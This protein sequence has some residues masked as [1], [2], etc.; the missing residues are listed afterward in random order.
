MGG[1]HAQF[2]QSKEAQTN[3]DNSDKRAADRQASR[4]ITREVRARGSSSRDDSRTRSSGLHGRAVTRNGI[5]RCVGSSSVG[6]N[7]DGAGSLC[8]GGG[9]GRGAVDAVDGRGDVLGRVVT[10]L[11]GED[12]DAKRED[13]DDELLEGTHFDCFGCCF[14]CVD[15]G[16]WKKKKKK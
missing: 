1:V 11:C 9:S 12:R 4:G 3:S 15:S 10:R 13:E 2:L 14:A 5:A 6:R 7:G 8:D 16:V